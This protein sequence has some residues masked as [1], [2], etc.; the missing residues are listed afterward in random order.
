[1]SEED[2][3]ARGAVQLALE[4]QLFGKFTSRR[5][6]TNVGTTPVVILNNNPERIG[7]VMVNRTDNRITFDLIQDVS[8]GVGFI[9]PETGD[10]VTVNYLEDGQF[11][12]HEISAVCD[13]AAGAIFLMEFIRYNL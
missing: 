12:T 13:N 4:Q 3:I 10:T 11:P 2:L 8:D 9:L 6:T 1:M 5:S 7:W